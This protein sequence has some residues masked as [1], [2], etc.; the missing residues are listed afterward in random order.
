MDDFY[1]SL[2]GVIMVME[3][4]IKGL[5]K[6]ED[7]EITVVVPKIDKKYVDEFPYKVIRVPAAKLSH[8]GYSLAIPQL[9]INMEKKLLDEKFDIIHI[10]S[11]FIMGKLGIKIAEKLNIPCVATMHTRFDLE[12]KKLTKSDLLTKVLLKDL[13]RTFNKCDMCYGVNNKTCELFKKYG[14]Q[15]EIGVQITGTDIKLVDDIKKARNLVN[16]KYNIKDEELVFSFVGRITIVKNIVFL[17]EVLEKLKQKGLKFKMLFVGPFEDKEILEEK[18]KKSNLE[19]N[20]ILTGKILDRQMLANIYARSKLFLFPSLYDTNSLVQKEAASQ[21]IP[22]VFI[23][24][25]ITAELITDNING[26]LANNNINE[27][28]DKILEIINNDELYKKVSEG[29]Y[30]DIFVSWDDLIEP[31]YKDYIKIIEN[32][33]K[34]F[35]LKDQRKTTEIKEKIKKKVKIIYVDNKKRAINTIKRYVLKENKK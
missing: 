17:V 13:V 18:I 30:K 23:K 34:N 29:A 2:N 26:F 21:K 32:K 25:A 35:K 24:E 3:N 11:P 8:I 4:H 10:H 28:A 1:P 33:K 27:Y 5:M 22:T 19:E 15:N 12:I 9:D 20:V 31:L 14:I 6:K 7:V 16:K